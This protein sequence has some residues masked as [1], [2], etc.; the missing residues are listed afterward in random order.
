M[1]TRTP[2]VAITITGVAFADNGVNKLVTV[3]FD[4]AGVGNLMDNSSTTQLRYPRFYLAKLVPGAT[5]TASGTAEPDTWVRTVSGERK[6]GNLTQ[7]DANS[8]SYQFEYNVPALDNAYTHRVGIY[9]SGVTGEITR[10]ATLDAVPNGSAVT[11][12]RDIVTTAACQQ[13]HDPLG[14]NALGETEDLV[15][16]GPGAAFHGGA[17]NTAE[18]CVLCH[19]TIQG[20]RDNTVVSYNPVS[21]LFE[22]TGAAHYP[23]MIHKIHGSHQLETSWVFHGKDYSEITYPQDIRNCATC[24]KGADGADWKNRPS[25]VGCGSCHTG[26]NFV[27]G[28]GHLGGA[29]AN[30]QFCAL[31]HT[32]TAIEGY[33]ATENSTPNNP[34]LHT[35]LATFE[36]NIS[37]VTVNASNQAVV[38]FWIKKNGTAVNLKDNNALTG[39][40]FGPSF[41]VAYANNVTNPKDYSNFGKSAGQPASVTL[42]SLLSSLTSTDNVTFTATL[43]AQPFPAGAKMRAIALQGYFTQTNVDVDGDGTNDS[44]GRHTPSV[45]KGVTGDATRRITVKSGYNLTTGQPEGCLECHEIFEGHGGNRVNNVQVCVMCHNPSL[46]TS[47]RTSTDT[48]I[49]AELEAAYPGG[50]LTYPE[51]SNNMKDMIHGVHGGLMRTTKFEDM[52]FRSG[53]VSYYDF[54]EVTYPGDLRNCEK[55]H[56]PGTY[57]VGLATGVDFSTVKVTTGNAAEATADIVAARGTVPN[58]TDLVTSPVVGACGMCH[59]TD[60][61]R[62]HFVLNGGNIQATREYAEKVPE[63]MSVA[64][65]TP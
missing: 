59:D 27:T 25:I 24:H 6:H 8:F 44:V 45:D 18:S 4:Y 62:S 60:T 43:T 13:C 51:V 23:Y 12:T 37:S 54:S 41:L 17:R 28:A 46:T 53:N 36:Y 38:N 2:L 35:G 64:L 63:T 48:T 56:L 39:F 9:T 22:G 42:S 15:E 3:N 58:V 26:V 11:V 21:G 47:G 50:A 16:E 65:P 33:H 29:A 61:A 32:A 20:T 55:C 40:T 31:C 10:F 14:F 34:Q 7:V 30:N 1:H 5:Y 52:R 49:A 19:R 57:G